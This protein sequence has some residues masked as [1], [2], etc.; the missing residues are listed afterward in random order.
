[1]SAGRSSTLSTG[2]DAAEL[3][4]GVAE[5]RQAEG[6]QLA[7][8]EEPA[9]E[10]EQQVADGRRPWPPRRRGQTLRE[11]AGDRRRALA[12][13]RRDRA[14]DD[15]GAEVLEA[16]DEGLQPDVDDGGLAAEQEDDR[17]ALRR[18]P[19]EVLLDLRE[20]AEVAVPDLERRLELILRAVRQQ[21][22]QRR[23][24]AEHGLDPGVPRLD[25]DGLVGDPLERVAD[26][27]DP[28]LARP[29]DPR[30]RREERDPR[31]IERP[32]LRRRVRPD[33][34]LR[35]DEPQLPPALATDDLALDH[36]RERPE[37]GRADV[38]GEPAR[39]PVL[40]RTRPGP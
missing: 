1:C 14:D 23:I 2:S 38:L 6:R 3:P 29:V 7:A 33:G 11:G 16:A 27:L 5:R 10:P 20:Q 12:E 26:A 8:R 17:P 21:H 32:P 31:R 39:R 15:C 36:L 13:D 34:E 24:A 19:D 4:V 30:A 22:E 9:A 18:G 40:R 28:A 35:A 37:P 25:V